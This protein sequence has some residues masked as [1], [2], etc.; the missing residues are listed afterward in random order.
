M[1]KRI[2][3]RADIEIGVCPTHVKFVGGLVPA[4]DGKL[5]RD[6]NGELFAV[7]EMRRLIER[8]PVKID[9]VQ[10]SQFNGTA[11]DDLAEIYERLQGLG[12]AKRRR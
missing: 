6:E 4:D 5:P 8:S 12:G 3:L 9:S 7:A 2:K 11:A 10:I 1:D